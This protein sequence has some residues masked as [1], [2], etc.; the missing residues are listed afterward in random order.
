MVKFR[1]GHFTQNHTCA[2]LFYFLHNQKTTEKMQNCGGNQCPSR[3][4]SGGQHTSKLTPPARTS[5]CAYTLQPCALKPLNW[6]KA[7]F[8]LPDFL[9]F[10]GL[11]FPEVHIRS[12]ITSLTWALINTGGISTAFCSISGFSRVSHRLITFPVHK[13]ART[14]PLIC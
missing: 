4:A 10:P 12:F 1:A 7:E 8:I 11:L 6:H 14:K 9:S 5:S 13:K 3:D 2:A